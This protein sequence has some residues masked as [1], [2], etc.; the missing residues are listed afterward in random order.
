MATLGVEAG[1]VAW[2]GVAWCSVVWH[3][4]YLCAG[5]G[6]DVLGVVVRSDVSGMGWDGVG[7]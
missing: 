5:G 1:G 6:V 7:E 4:R 3:S 2:R